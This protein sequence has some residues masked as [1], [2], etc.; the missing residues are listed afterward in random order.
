MWNSRPVRILWHSFNWLTRVAIVCA[1]AGLLVLA[2]GIIGL[3]YWLLPGIEQYHDKIT[4]SLTQSLGRTVTIEKI[5]GDWQGLRPR[6]SLVNLSVLDAQKQ[7]SLVLPEVHVSVSWLSVLSAEL[8]FSSLEVDRPEL[9]IRRDVQGN[10]FVGG[11]PVVEQADNDS[12]LADWLLLQ[13][14]M[15]A[16]DA[17]V[18]WVD[19]LR[20]AP[21]LV[22]ENVNV[23]IESF[24]NHHMFALRATVPS[25]LAS[26][27]DVRGDFRGSRFSDLGGWRGQVFS[28]LQ[29]ANITAWR[30]WLDMPKQFSQGRGAVRGWLDVSA[31]KFSRLQVDLAVRD[32]ATKLA[33]DVPEMTMKSLR[34]R[35][36]WHA[37]P[38]GFELETK[39]LTM[40]LENGVAL[41]TTDLYL[42]ILAAQ[43]KQLASGAI[44]ANALQLETLVS[45]TNFV[46]IPADLRNELDMFAP[47]GKV[48]DLNAQWEGTPQNLSGYAIKGKFR[49]IALHQVG[50]LPGFSGLSANISGNQ[51]HGMVSIKSRQL[52]VDAPGIL[53]DHVQFN[54]MASEASWR[55]EGS[56]LVVE[57]DRLALSNPDLEGVA[58]GS[59]RTVRD[60][61]G[62][63]DLDVNLK[64]ADI[65]QAARYTPLVAVNR[66]VNDWLH[67]ALLAGGSNDFHLRLLGNLNDFPFEQSGKGKFEITSQFHNATVHF[68]S[69]W[70]DIENANGRLL[71]SGKR[72]EVSCT[73]ATTTGVP[74]HEVVVQVPDITEA[75]PSL[76][77]KIKAAGD[78]TSFLRFIQLSPVRGYIN[79][80]TDPVVAQGNG[81]LDLELRIPRLGEPS[82]ELQGRFHIFNNQV[83]LGGRVPILRKVNGALQFTQTG[84]QT[85][86]L[87]AEIL[88]GPAQINVK[89][90]PDGEVAAAL[91]G[92]SNIDVWR[93]DHIFP[94]LGRVHG[95]AAWKAQIAASSK[96]MHVQISSSLQGLSSG[97]PVPFNKAQNDI[98][99]L[100]VNIDSGTV[101][102]I[103]ASL[104]EG[105]TNTK[106]ELGKLFAARVVLQRQHGAETIKRAAVN[107][108]GLAVW[109]E[110]DGVWLVGEVPELSVQ[111]WGGLK[112]NAGAP[113]SLL[114][115]P[116]IDGADL[117]IGKLTGYGH[118]IAELH[119]VARKS[120]DGM[121][122]QL[123]SPALHGELTWLPTGF[124][125][126]GK[127]VVRL[128][129][130]NW[131]AD[132]DIKDVQSISASIA[133][134]VE[135]GTPNVLLPGS[136][137]ALEVTVEQLQSSGKQLGRLE[138]VGH[139]DGDSWRLRRMLLTNPDGSL[140]GDGVWSGGGG[141]P[142]TKINLSLQI[143][144]AGKILDRSG[145]PNAV[146]DGSGKLSASL[147]WVGAPEAFN[148]NTLEGNLKLDTGKGQ[149]L[150]VDPGVG[151]L[152]SVLSLQALP[153]HI[154]LDF[155]DVFS[156]GFQFDNIN[157]NAHIHD[158]KMTTQD[159]HIDGSAAKVL[160]KGSVDLN[161][162]T[163][164][165]RVEILPNIGSGVSLISAFAINPLVGI[166][167]FVVDKILGNPLDKLVS[168][169][170]NISGTWANPSVVKLGE[171]PVPIVAKPQGPID[172]ASSDKVSDPSKTLKPTEK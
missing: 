88:G 159:F 170:Y 34:G 4:Q 107:F 137:P 97:L 84:L 80:F 125:D 2:F 31:G 136:L 143:S 73:N 89:T 51:D 169:E 24:F 45:L 105:Q 166:S 101:Q 162:E 151:K 145:F 75:V 36:I 20:G 15:V 133:A 96:F 65:R 148:L 19:E 21:P 33:E 71:L 163:Q 110:R 134:S 58:H 149:F 26:P 154:A 161:R 117:R 70:P 61:P 29:Y 165:L 56:E 115:P 64:R 82:V 109:P 127:L 104:P 99:P 41:P 142:Q 40:Q 12:R 90:T 135:V 112:N 155:T 91:S 28:Q 106:M 27:L 160:M 93:K 79:G 85:E 78:T 139:P 18:V 120:G 53:R 81:E 69:D 164:D 172:S 5:S 66:K 42:R 62:V 57:V 25:D 30:P 132:A 171:K 74:L 94:G 72:V 124:Q 46:P 141:K 152:L 118:G 98:L 14:R 140:S 52:E 23:R 116:Y 9:L 121:T 38:G 67:D 39:Q 60:T 16:R 8:R 153:K 77:V 44:R 150:K 102:G 95:G 123:V 1:V 68:A 86:Q 7:P 32:V 49:D 54:S 10:L 100:L 122:A 17:L 22:L 92:T 147:A 130:F 55:H 158:G 131:M 168:F 146:K 129:D 3:R 128:T 87:T 138:L 35:A 103:K 59:Y 167:A 108:G 111:G 113:Q 11:V 126:G 63:L 157:G 48:D 6:L 156:S 43:E 83:D 119:V 47:R 144:N 13:S 114:V 50:R 76:E 37:L